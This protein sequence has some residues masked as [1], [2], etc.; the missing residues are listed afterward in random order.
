ME[1]LLMLTQL[2]KSLLNEKIR[3]RLIFA[4]ILKNQIVEYG[5]FPTNQY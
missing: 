2:R 4:L 1:Q 3:D 5:D